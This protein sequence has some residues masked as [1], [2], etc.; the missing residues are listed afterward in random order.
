LQSDQRAERR[1]EER[2]NLPDGLAQLQVNLPQIRKTKLL[3]N[4][5]PNPNFALYGPRA[6]YWLQ[7]GQ[8]SDPNYRLPIIKLS[9]ES[10][11]IFNA[12]S[13]ALIIR[14]LKLLFARLRNEDQLIS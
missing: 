4:E 10:N 12:I 13:H 14:D 11:Q 6:R 9:H 3:P 1:N 5:A 7:H 2:Q 8:Q